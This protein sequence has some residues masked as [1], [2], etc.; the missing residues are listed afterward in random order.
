VECWQ[1]TLPSGAK[2]YVHQTIACSKNQQTWKNETHAK[3]MG[4]PKSKSAKSKKHKSKITEK[5]CAKKGLSKRG[6]KMEKMDLSICIFA[7]N[8]FSFSICF[9]GFQV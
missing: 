4:E 5:N 8:Y 3:K 7:C 1:E 2:C 9:F 6:T